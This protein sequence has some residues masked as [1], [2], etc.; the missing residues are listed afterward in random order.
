[1][2]LKLVWHMFPFLILILLCNSMVSAIGEEVFLEPVRPDSLRVT[3]DGVNVRIRWYPPTD[4]LIS[5]IGSVFYDNW[6]YRHE[7]NGVKVDFVGDYTGSIDRK[8]RLSLTDKGV[9]VVGS[10]PEIQI[11]MECTDKFWKYDKL[12]RKFVVEYETYSKRINIGIFGLEY[13]DTI[14][15]V[16]RGGDPFRELDLGFSVYFNDGLVDTT[17]GGLSASLNV[18]LQTFEGFNVWRKE[19]QNSNSEVYP[20]QDS[21]KAIAEISKEE[22]YLYSKINRQD[23]IPPK[24]LENWEYFTDYGEEDAYPRVD[25][26]GGK[27]LV[28]YEWVDKNVFPGFKYYYSVSSYDR[29]YYMGV[30][31]DSVV[32]SFVCDNDSIPCSGIMES[33]WVGAPYT[34]TIDGVYAVPNPFRTGSSAQTTPYYHNYDDGDYVKFHH[35]PPHAKLRIFTVSGDLVWKTVFD[36]PDNGEGIIKWDGRNMKGM[37]VSSGIFIYRC[38]DS[39]G[40]D[41]YGK[42][43]VIRQSY[44]R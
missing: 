29:G 33:I 14:P 10:S 9:F 4:S 26:L 27:K 19:V 39:S 43:I 13:G 30:C 22:Y 23:E 24:R 1:M 5:T 35:V 11:I 40:A 21:M 17:E 34:G 8:L 36:S 16:L 15:V 31:K 25:T 37:L 44:N 38:E 3:S 6:N 2:R 12:A 28:Y 42:L 7:T 18:D 41:T 32:E 20:S